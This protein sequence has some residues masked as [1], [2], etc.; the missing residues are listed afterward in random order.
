MGSTGRVTGTH[1]HFE[2][3][4]GGIGKAFAVD[5]MPLVRSGMQR[6][7]KNSTEIL[8]NSCDNL[9]AK[10]RGGPSLPGISTGGWGRSR[11]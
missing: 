3:Y 4:Q 5:P 2:V 7:S 9:R 6:V 10:I 8:N 11:R 1:L